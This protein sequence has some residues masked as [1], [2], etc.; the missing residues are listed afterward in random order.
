MNLVRAA[1]ESNYGGYNAYVI[2]DSQVNTTANLLKEILIE[3]YVSLFG[4]VEAF[5]DV[6][7]TSNLIGVPVNN[8]TALPGRFLYPQ[9]EINSNANT[10]V[11]SQSDLFVPVDLYK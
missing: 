3:K 6:R 2:T 1:H 10:P 5:N 7:R 4:Q 8:G 9:S 11:Q